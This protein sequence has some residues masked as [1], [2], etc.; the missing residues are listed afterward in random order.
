MLVLNIIYNF[1]N[2]LVLSKNT[3]ENVFIQMA[4]IV[5]DLT[6]FVLKYLELAR[7][8]YQLLFA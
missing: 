6:V 3:F 5:S 4:T 8:Y 2:I 1:F 7:L